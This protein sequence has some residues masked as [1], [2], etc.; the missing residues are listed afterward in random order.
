MLGADRGRLNFSTISRDGGLRLKRAMA[1]VVTAAVA[2]TL[3]VRGGEDHQ[4]VVEI[5][6]SR[7]DLWPANSI[8]LGVVKS[9]DALATDA[10]FI[11]C[12]HR[13]AGDQLVRNA[14]SD[15]PTRTFV[16][17]RSAEP[18]IIRPAAQRAMLRGV[19]RCQAVRSMTSV[20]HVDQERLRR[21]TMSAPAPSNAREI[22][23]GSGTATRPSISALPL[24]TSTRT[25]SMLARVTL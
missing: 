25:N 11:T 15:T 21:A 24:R 22:A 5:N 17:R 23:V 16:G 19:V 13:N 9:H 18:A 1:T 8:L 2:A 10:G 7:P 4:A 14:L 6:V 20:C 12:F 3:M